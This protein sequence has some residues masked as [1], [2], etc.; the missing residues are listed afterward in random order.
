MTGA[1]TAQPQTLAVAEAMAAVALGALGSPAVLVSL[2]SHAAQ[3][4]F[5]QVGP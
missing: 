4:C 3:Q 2:V 5:S 1:L